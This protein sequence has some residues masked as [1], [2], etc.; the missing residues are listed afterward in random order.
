MAYSEFEKH[1]AAKLTTRSE[2]TKKESCAYIS[3]YLHRSWTHPE[4]V[5]LSFTIF[6]ALVRDSFIQE[7]L[8]LTIVQVGHIRVLVFWLQTK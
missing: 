2:E 4:Q 8:Q 6:R 1:S 7:C 3:S 5:T